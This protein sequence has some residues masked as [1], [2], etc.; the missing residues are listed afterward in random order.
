MYTKETAKQGHLERT[1]PV[2]AQL[3][4][5]HGQNTAQNTLFLAGLLLLNG[6]IDIWGTQCKAKSGKSEGNVDPEALGWCILKAVVQC[7][8]ARPDRHA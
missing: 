4:C 2:K 7:I 6:T 3:W 8:E 1:K 5:L